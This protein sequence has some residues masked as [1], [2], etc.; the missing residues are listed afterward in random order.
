MTNIRVTAGKIT[1]T[2]TLDDSKC[3]GVILDSLP[4]QS[5]A[6]RWGD[7]VYFGIPVDAPEEDPQAEVPPGGVGYWPPG[8]ALCLFFGEKPYSPVNIIGQI[9]G[10]PN[11]LADVKDGDTVHVERA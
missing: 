2:A 6:R 3:A 9:D 4:I 1:V 5:E 11:V 7:E 8:R 10:D